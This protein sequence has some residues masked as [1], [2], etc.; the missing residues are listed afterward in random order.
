[1]IE[2]D[3]VVKWFSSAKGYGFVVGDN[4]Q[5]YFV[6]FKSIISDEPY[7]TLDEGQ[8]VS[9]IPAEGSRGKVAGNVSLIK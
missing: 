7:K 2:M 8:K 5:E 9:F 1:M 6:H 4:D 3:G